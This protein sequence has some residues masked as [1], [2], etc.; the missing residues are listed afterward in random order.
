MLDQRQ[1]GAPCAVALLSKE[2][3]LNVERCRDFGCQSC[4]ASL[5]SSKDTSTLMHALPS[6]LLSPNY[7]RLEPVLLSLILSVR[8]LWGGCDISVWCPPYVSGVLPGPIKLIFNVH[9]SLDGP[10][11]GWH[12]C[13]RDM[14]CPHCFQQQQWKSERSHTCNTASPA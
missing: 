12:S 13:W 2:N 8:G 6:H 7:S 9:P 3:N 10:V 5:I 11:Q 4:L 14:I 1:K